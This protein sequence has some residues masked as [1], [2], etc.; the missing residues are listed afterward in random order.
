MV[1]SSPRYLVFLAAVL[2]LLAI[3]LALQRKKRLLVV[4][5]SLFSAAWDWRYL[6]L[7]VTISVIDYVAADRIDR[8][9]RGGGGARGR[10]LWLFASIAS[11]LAILGWFKYCGFFLHNLNGVLASFGAATIAV[12]QILLPAGLS[13][14]T[15]K[16]MSYTI[17]LYR[18]GIAPCRS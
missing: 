16:S 8:S 18:R 3:P 13:F 1:F 9:A 10:K 6:G 14:Y 7:L 17:D 12:P 4:A 2:L 11:N 15:F 5:P